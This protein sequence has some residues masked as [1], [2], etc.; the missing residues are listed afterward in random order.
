MLTQT[1][2]RCGIDDVHEMAN[3]RCLVRLI[4]ILIVLGLLEVDPVP[5]PEWA[6]AETVIVGLL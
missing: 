5:D 6:Y 3:T 1:I 4:N 2:I